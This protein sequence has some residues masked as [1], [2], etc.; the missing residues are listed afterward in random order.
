MTELTNLCSVTMEVQDPPHYIQLAAGR[1]VTNSDIDANPRSRPKQRRLVKITLIILRCVYF[2]AI[3][4]HHAANGEL[5]IYILSI[6]RERETAVPLGNDG[7]ARRT[8]LN[9]PTCD[10]HRLSRGAPNNHRG[11][12][13]VFAGSN[14]YTRVGQR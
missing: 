2:C 9:Y 8:S 14:N 7:M 1:T 5:K 12:R 10:E 6:L 3:H 4:L 11:R 13:S